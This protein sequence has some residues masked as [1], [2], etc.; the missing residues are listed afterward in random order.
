MIQ[1]DNETNSKATPRTGRRE[2]LKQLLLCGVGLA[3]L[4]TSV[5]L[6]AARSMV[7]DEK[8]SVSGLQLR[9]DTIWRM[10][11]MGDGFKMTWAADDRQFAVLNDGTGWDHPPKAFIKR[12][13][14]SFSGQ[15]PAVTVHPVPGYPNINSS[16]EADDAPDYRGHSLLAVKGK[17]YQFLCTLDHGQGRLRHW[18]AVKLI[19]SED[20]GRTWRNQDGSHPVRFEDWSE[21]SSRSL[22]FFNTPDGCFSILS[23]LQMGRDYGANRDGYVYVYSPN[24]NVDGLMN[25]LMMFRV[26]VDRVLDRAAY[27]FFCGKNQS[28]R[29]KWRKD[30]AE[31]QPVHVFPQGWVNSTE[32]FPDDIVVETWLPSVVYN[33]ALGL[34]M[35]VATGTGCAPDGTE[36]GRPGYM[37][38][39]LAATPWGPWRQ[40]HE[41]K[42]WTPGGDLESRPYSAQ[43]PPKWIA[44]DG[45]SL[46]L[47]WTDLKG[48]RSLAQPSEAPD[49]ASGS[50]TSNNKNDKPD[51]L[52]VGRMM[53]E[54]MPLYSL[55]AQRL[56]LLF[57]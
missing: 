9:D 55:N 42:A 54:A 46:W 52:A 21:Q 30:M 35:M 34:Y 10:S 13:L 48:I 53:N 47:V 8:H 27:E 33:E 28:G 4:P 2:T 24:G 43:I 11:G 45:K 32:L 51:P 38:F 20:A 5:P 25:Q 22:A 40:I 7:R 19:Y 17:I 50:S 26:P 1:A 18:N 15:P 12:S 16:M 39:W 41:D 14:W 57:D 36:F 31:R 49:A 29:P 3:T 56:D 6:R 37:G 44:P 23:F